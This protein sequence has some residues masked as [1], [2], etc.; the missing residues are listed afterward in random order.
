MSSDLLRLSILIVSYNTREMTL[1]C[2]EFVRREAIDQSYELIVIDNASTD[3][4]AE[5]IATQFP[6]ISLIASKENLGFARANNVAA[7]QAQGEYLLLLN[8]DTVV[9][10]HAVDNLM[11]FARGKS[12]GQDLGWA[13]RLCRQKAQSW[14]LFAPHDGL[15]AL[16]HCGWADRSISQQC[17][18]QL[19]G[20][21]SLATRLKR[22]VDVVTG[23]FFLIPTSFWRELRGFDPD[24]FMYAEEVDLCIRAGKAGADPLFT[25]E[26]EI[27]HYAGASSVPMRRKLRRTSPGRSLSLTSTG[28]LF[29]V[30]SCP[31]CS[32]STHL[33]EPQDSHWRES[34]SG[35][36]ATSQKPK[37][38]QPSGEVAS[39]G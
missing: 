6:E 5:A 29:D 12:A 11:S 9:L 38:G 22:P 17:R 14:I 19:G 26:A 37:N 23:C 20:L 10:D 24:F 28:R 16:L 2:I 13:D 8:P 32:R 31:T 36:Q 25:P 7:E 30:G 4:S 1:A 34:F 33:C 39:S 21:R 3:G 27:V 18:L 15:V 35:A